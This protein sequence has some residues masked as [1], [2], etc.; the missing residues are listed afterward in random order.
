M[1]DR[2]VPRPAQNI[3][4]DAL[5]VTHLGDNRIQ[6]EAAGGQKITIEGNASGVLIEDAGGS[7]IQLQGGTIQIRSSAQVSVQCSSVSIS[8]AMITVDAAMTKFSGT[9]QADTVITNNVVASSY[10]PGAGN[11][12]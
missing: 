12:S 1:V 3:R 9:V 10:T 6:I 11:I 4:T 5:K 2:H 8:A 7:S